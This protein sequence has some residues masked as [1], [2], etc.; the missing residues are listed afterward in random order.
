MRKT[1]QAIPIRVLSYDSFDAFVD[2]ASAPPNAQTFKTNDSS[3]TGKAPFCGGATWLENAKLARHGW[4]EGE[5]MVAKFRSELALDLPV[6]ERHDE[7]QPILSEEGDDVMVDRYLD[8]ETDCWHGWQNNEVQRE[9]KIVKL[10]YD[11]AA[12]AAVPA[13]TLQ[14]RGAGACALIDALESSGYRVEVEIMMHSNGTGGG[15]QRFKVTLKRPEQDLDLAR[16]AYALC[17]PSVL[18]RLWFRLGEQLNPEQFRDY[19]GYGYGVIKTPPL[20]ETQGNI[21]WGRLNTTGTDA[22]QVTAKVMSELRKY[23]R[24]EGLPS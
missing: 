8:G 18:R 2:A 13:S 11:I 1:G 16:L 10:Q 14:T 19:Y 3:V 17:H 9:G 24:V 22:E 7:F 20:S 12:S 15:E 6:L 4:P 21:Y 5:K 23:V